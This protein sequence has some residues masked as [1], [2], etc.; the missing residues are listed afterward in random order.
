MCPTKVI[1]LEFENLSES[2][3]NIP[4][5]AGVRAIMQFSTEMKM[6]NLGYNPVI[7]GLPTDMNTIYTGIK[8]VEN[9]TR[10]LGQSTPV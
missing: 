4:S 7:Q 9:Q 3:Q 6:T 5:W 10:M 8:I 1:T 2:E